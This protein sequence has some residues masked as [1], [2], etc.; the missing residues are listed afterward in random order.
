MRRRRGQGTIEKTRYGFRPRLPGHG[1]RRLPT[2]GTHDEAEDV[3][4]GALAALYADPAQGG[5]S[6]GTWG[7]TV[8]DRR[9]LSG[10]RDVDNDRSRWKTHVADTW[11]GAV[12]LVS[13]TTIDVANWTK[14]L[15]TR[16]V[17]PG[18]NHGA[19]VVA[20]RAKTLIGKSTAQNALN[21]LRVVLQ[22]AV[23]TGMLVA[24]PA[25]NVKLPRGLR[26][27]PRTHETWTYLKPAEQALI[28]SAAAIPER[29]RLAIQFAIA[30]GIRQ[31]EQWQIRLEDVDIKSREVTVRFTKNGK[32]RTVPL[33]DLAIDAL[34]RWL[35]LL[36]VETNANRARAE[37]R[38]EVWAPSGLLW[39]RVR[40]TA[41][42]ND[43]DK[44][45]VW[46]DAVGLTAA[47][48]TDGKHVRWHDLRH[49]CGTS[50]A[51][52]WWGR[53]WSKEEI[54]EMLDH[55]S[56]TTTERYV[57]IAESLLKTA[58]AEARDLTTDLTTSI[59]ARP[60]NLSD[61]LAPPARLERTTFGLG[62]LEVPEPATEVT[63]D[64]GSEVVRRLRERALEALL[65]RSAGRRGK[66][67]EAGT[68]LAGE[69]LA[70]C[71][72]ALA[73]ELASVAGA[74]S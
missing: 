28:L 45:Q 44:W 69:V 2:C 30:T 56:I 6:L 73:T 72:A 62:N 36:V 41:R 10:L 33:L 34:E 49:T 25:A 32:P 66:A 18:A 15:A 42:A 46:L 5:M 67:L 4:A 14:E 39:P 7:E 43:P 23:E 17:R 54:Q 70:W 31:D 74:V 13:V 52:G 64:P 61:S 63:S 48:R 71:D 68:T 47:K 27:R 9:E 29:E 19:K 40:G 65:A 24:N 20:A 26:K 55:E 37:R 21:L 35:P 1:A 12:A 53:R 16:R 50:L 22:E 58:A 11:L 59:R 57:H 8:M 3:L 60:R 51:C 38:R